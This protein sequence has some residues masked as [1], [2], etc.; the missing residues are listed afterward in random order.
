[1][2]ANFAPRGRYPRLARQVREIVPSGGN[3]VGKLFVLSI[4]IAVGYMIGWRDAQSNVDHIASRAVQMVRTTFGANAAND[5]DSRMSKLEG[6][7]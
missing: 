5:I 2:R 7:N 1:M 4:A 6:K 3:F